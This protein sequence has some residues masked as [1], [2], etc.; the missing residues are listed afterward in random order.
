M[1]TVKRKFEE[2]ENGP[3]LYWI[4]REPLEELCFR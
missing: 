3:F 1:K 4:H 2:G